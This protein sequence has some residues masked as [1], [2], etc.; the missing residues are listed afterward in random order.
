MDKARKVL[1]KASE[2]GFGILFGC[3][4]KL[5]KMTSSRDNWVGRATEFCIGAVLLIPMWI[6]LEMGHLAEGGHL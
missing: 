6:T 2:R 3:G 4:T 5:A 1:E